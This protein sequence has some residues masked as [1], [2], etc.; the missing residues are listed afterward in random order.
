MRMRRVFAIVLTLCM[1]LVLLPTPKA[2]AAENKMDLPRSEDEMRQMVVD[3]ALQLSQVEWTC[4]QDIDF[5]KAVSWSPDLFYHAGTVYRGLPYAS[6]RNSGNAN[7]DEFLAA[8]DG[9]GNYAGPVAWNEI[10]ASDC[11]G[12]VRLAYAW[13]GALCGLELE[14][15][16]FDPGEES[17]AFGLIPLGDYDARGY[18]RSSS[19]YKTIN[20]PN[21]EER[22][23]NCYYMQLNV[24]D[25]S[26]YCGYSKSNFCKIFKEITG[27]TFHNTLNS[28]R[29]DV[30]C[31]LLHD[32][33]YT[34]EKIAQETGFTDIKSF[35][36]VFKKLKGQNASEY[37]KNLKEK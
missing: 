14:E 32:T 15:L 4:Q 29:I 37:R 10:P 35:C 24:E 31:M 30:A 6:D 27:E 19:T 8:R 7:L 5:T 26:T 21:G 13:A 28:H 11:G 1:V 9:E 34:I 22:I 23:Y 17:A 18:N 20:Q 3:Y 16:V 12:Q 25:V 2:Q 36:R 33:N